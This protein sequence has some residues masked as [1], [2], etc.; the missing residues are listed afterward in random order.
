MVSNF[1]CD[2]D[3]RLGGQGGQNQ[4][5]KSLASIS[6]CPNDRSEPRGAG[7]CI[8]S[9]A[10]PGSCWKHAWNEHAGS[11]PETSMLEA[12]LGCGT[13]MLEARLGYDTGMPR[14]LDRRFAW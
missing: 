4:S 12:R 5:S 14:H 1:T 7:Q 6:V 13:S 3:W 2:R 10:R 8:R 11:T 9:S